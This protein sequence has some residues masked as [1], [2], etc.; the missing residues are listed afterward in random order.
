MLV[1]NAV[2][3]VDVSMVG[4][5]FMQDRVL[6]IPHAE[7]HALPVGLLVRWVGDESSIYLCTMHLVD[8]Y[9]SYQKCKLTMPY[10]V[11]GAD[12]DYCWTLSISLLFGRVYYL[13]FKLKLTLRRKTLSLERC[14]TITLIVKHSILRQ[15]AL[16]G[17]GSK[18]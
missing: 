16:H 17:A 12:L 13:V 9:S 1:Q 18:C 5:N 7:Q 15:Y 4:P 6:M 3:G 14:P 10:E 8:D 11:E 2:F